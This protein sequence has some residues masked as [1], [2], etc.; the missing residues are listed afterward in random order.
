MRSQEGRGQQY[1]PR[2]LR[3]TGLCVPAAA[4]RI[5]TKGTANPASK[6]SRRHTELSTNYS[7]KK[8]QPTKPFTSKK[9]SKNKSTSPVT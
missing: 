6:N 1:N 3:S 7:N 2:M 5:S 9:S 8:H 4:Q